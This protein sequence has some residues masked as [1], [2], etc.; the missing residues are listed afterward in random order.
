MLCSPQAQPCQ[1]R[2]SEAMPPSPF[3]TE[4]GAVL[5]CCR[6]F[7][8]S[9]CSLPSPLH[10]RPGF[11][12]SFLCFRIQIYTLFFFPHRPRLAFYFVLL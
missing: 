1:A 11:F 2:A 5:G 10:I 12:S 3:A 9:T 7:M 8:L 6:F 4:T